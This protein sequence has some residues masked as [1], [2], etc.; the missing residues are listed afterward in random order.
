MA[1]ALVVID[2]QKDFTIGSLGTPEACR[3]APY[4]AKLVD[5]FLH[6]GNPIYYTMDTHD[7]NYLETQEGINLPIAHCI[8]DSDGW[9]ILDGIDVKS[10]E[11]N[12]VYHLNKDT[13]SYDFWE[14]EDLEL[15]KCEEIYICGFVSS[16]CVIANALALKT[17]YPE[18]P[19]KFVSYA[20]AGL[21]PENHK[22]AIE[23]MRS[24]Q[25]EII[26]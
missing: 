19:I 11:F 10:T 23:V 26:D 25:I 20:S 22:A 3:A 12:K 14:D 24:C 9:Q 5:E 18:I 8:L 17:A 6:E 16:I 4:I 2:A 21:T 7:T 15:D 1:R 13:F